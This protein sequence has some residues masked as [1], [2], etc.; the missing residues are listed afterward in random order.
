ME[1]TGLRKSQRFVSLVKE[2]RVSAAAFSVALEKASCGRLANLFV[3]AMGI[4]PSD[5]CAVVIPMSP[6]PQTVS[7][8][9]PT[10]GLGKL[11]VRELLNSPDVEMEIR[12]T[13]A[14]EHKDVPFW[15]LF[16]VALYK[17]TKK[18]E[19]NGE[20]IQSIS[21]RSESQIKRAECTLARIKNS[22]LNDT[23]IFVQ[24]LAQIGFVGLA[25]RVSIRAGLSSDKPVIHGPQNPSEV[26]STKECVICH[27]RPTSVMLTDSTYACTHKCVCHIC[28][29]GIVDCPL[30]RRQIFLRFA[31]N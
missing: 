18:D 15:E 5:S 21:V 20:A 19:F 17:I 7:A 30:C 23:E 22:T 4:R 25:Q 31:P 6:P 24:A 27:E 16:I 3:L 10:T 29:L 28:A 2:S 26:D 13:L 1:D 12:R 9:S 8:T 14:I 11:T